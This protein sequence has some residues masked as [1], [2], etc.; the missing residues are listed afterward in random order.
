M[1]ALKFKAREPGNLFEERTKKFKVTLYFYSQNYYE[2]K[3]KLHFIASG[4]LGGEEKDKKIFL[5]DLRKDKKVTFLES[6][7]D[8]LIC[9]Y[10]ESIKGKRAAVQVAY[11]PRLI[12]LKP[13]I[14]D[15]EI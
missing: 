11:N 5:K 7:K 4:I 3:G 15:K 12:F 8:F 6:H 1:W 10:A 2:E 13:A 9:I 14:I